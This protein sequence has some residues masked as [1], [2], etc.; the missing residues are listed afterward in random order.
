M[1]AVHIQYDGTCHFLE[2]MGVDDVVEPE[3]VE[4]SRKCVLWIEPS[5]V[6]DDV[7]IANVLK[8]MEDESFQLKRI[9]KIQQWTSQADSEKIA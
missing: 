3:V 1:T 6:N 4:I 8:E 7:H 9:T 5:L 2:F